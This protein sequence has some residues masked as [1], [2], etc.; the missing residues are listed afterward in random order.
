MDKDVRTVVKIPIL[1]GTNYDSWKPRM[2]T[3]IK[4]LGDKAWK[5]VVK[6]W[7]PPKVVDAEG[8]ATDVLKPEEGLDDNDEASSQGNSKALNFIFNR[9]DKNVFKLIKN[10][11]SAKVSWETLRKVQEGS[12]KVKMAKL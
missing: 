5:N 6:G 4:S 7:D 9:V 10:C 3:F 2:E 8:K 11:K 12:S 1:D